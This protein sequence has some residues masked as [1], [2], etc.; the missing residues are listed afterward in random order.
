[1]KIII[2]EMRYSLEEFNRIFEE[3]EE[4]INALHER[5]IEIIK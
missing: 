5:I 4:R 2:T 3:A 1:M